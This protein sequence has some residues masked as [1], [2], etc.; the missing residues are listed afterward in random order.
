MFLV[1]VKMINYKWVRLM[2]TL[3]THIK[4]FIFR[5][6]LSGIEKAVITFSILEKFF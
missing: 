1:S 6:I 3:R 4:L 5:N 2:C